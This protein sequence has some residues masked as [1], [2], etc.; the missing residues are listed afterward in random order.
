M[1]IRYQDDGLRHLTVSLGLTVTWTAMERDRELSE[2]TETNL[3]HI[4][5]GKEKDRHRGPQWCDSN[6]V[7]Y[8]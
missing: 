8:L 7:K 1:L 4:Q 6:Y 5:G 3:S 2:V